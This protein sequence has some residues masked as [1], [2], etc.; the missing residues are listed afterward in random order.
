VMVGML[1]N[2]DRERFH[3]S[4]S[5]YDT[6]RCTNGHRWDGCPAGDTTLTC[7]DC[8]LRTA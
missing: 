3:V 8:G 5:T 7:L 2:M 6:I 4:D 1:R